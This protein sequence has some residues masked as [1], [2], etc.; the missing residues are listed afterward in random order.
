MRTITPPRLAAMTVAILLAAVRTALPQMP[1]LDF[2]AG[3]AGGGADL[4]FMARLFASHPA[5]SAKSDVRV[6]DKNQNETISTPMDFFY[7]DKKM[8]VEIDMSKMKNKDLPAGVLEQL[9]QFGMDQVVSIIRPDRKTMHVLYP[10][11]KA[12]VTLPLPKADAEDAAPAALAKEPVGKEALDGRAC[13]KNKVTFTSAKGEKQERTVW[14]A[15]DLKDFPVQIL[16]VQNDDTVITR[17][18]QIQF[19]KPEARLFD[20][21]ADFKEYTDMQSFMQGVMSQILG[22]GAPTAK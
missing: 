19:T 4:A 1:T 21:P 16:G 8:R 11:L 22:G 9:K 6:Y 7:L 17:Y 14:Y 2:S 20:P 3:P 12:C 15:K 13:V 10:K 18:R 5:F